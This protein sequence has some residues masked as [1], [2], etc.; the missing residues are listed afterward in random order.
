MIYLIC[1]TREDSQ[2][3]HCTTAHLEGELE[4]VSRSE[5]LGVV[6]LENDPDYPVPVVMNMIP[7]P[8][9]QVAM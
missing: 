7:A 9:K 8:Q 6:Q 3:K 1:A 5:G 2:R 4:A